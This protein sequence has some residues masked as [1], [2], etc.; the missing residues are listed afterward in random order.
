MQ[1]GAVGIL[2]PVAQLRR[3]ELEQAAI[4]RLVRRARH[5]RPIEHLV[6]AVVERVFGKETVVD[7]KRTFRTHHAHRMAR[8]GRSKLHEHK[9]RSGTRKRDNVVAMGSPLNQ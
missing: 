1:E 5:A 6:V 8:A 4:K 2:L 9:C 3:R 7:A